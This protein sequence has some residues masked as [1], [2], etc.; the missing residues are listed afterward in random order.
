[1][2]KESSSQNIPFPNRGDRI[3]KKKKGLVLT[4]EEKGPYSKREKN[5]ITKEHRRGRKGN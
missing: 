1:M 4:V 3:R 5:L 2:R